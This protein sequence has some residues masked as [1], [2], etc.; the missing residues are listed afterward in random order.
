[1]E[2]VRGL[3]LGGKSTPQD[4]VLPNQLNMHDMTMWGI[5]LSILLWGKGA[6][7][8]T[9]MQYATMFQSE[10]LLSVFSWGAI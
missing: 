6:E 3:L 10:Q 1:M 8:Y 4:Q 2:I 5:C 9:A 7:T